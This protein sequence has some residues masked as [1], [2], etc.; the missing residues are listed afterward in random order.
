MQ[1]LF[2][3][4]NQT[5]NNLRLQLLLYLGSSNGS[6]VVTAWRPG[7]PNW[8]VKGYQALITQMPVGM[9]IHWI[10]ELALEK[11]HVVRRHPKSQ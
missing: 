8:P 7:H 4:Y 6:V 5:E 1:I 2:V 9:G 10:G 3:N 11:S